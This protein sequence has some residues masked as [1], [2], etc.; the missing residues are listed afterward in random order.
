MRGRCADLMTRMS[1]KCLWNVGVHSYTQGASI[2]QHSDDE[3]AHENGV[4]KDFVKEL[5]H[6]SLIVKITLSV[7]NHPQGY[8]IEGSWSVEAS[9]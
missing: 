2:D 1:W 8:F 3:H 7:K 5:K 9:D 6:A 4:S